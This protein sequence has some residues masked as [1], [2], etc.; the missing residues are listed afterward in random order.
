[1]EL[2]F[3]WGNLFMSGKFILV[4]WCL[5]NIPQDCELYNIYLLFSNYYVTRSLAG[6][7]YVLSHLSIT[8]TLYER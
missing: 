1:M 8:M 4:H 7:L 3:H 2:A 5:D 6:A